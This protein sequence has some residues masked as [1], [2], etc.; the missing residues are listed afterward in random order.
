MNFIKNVKNIFSGKKEGTPISEASVA[1][2]DTSNTTSNEVEY[3]KPF[4]QPEPPAM[5]RVIRL[6][7]ISSDLFPPDDP[8]KILIKAQPTTTGDQCL[9]MLNRSLFP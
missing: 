5:R 6:S 7:P 2:A 1:A 3:D 9:F 4:S 8:D